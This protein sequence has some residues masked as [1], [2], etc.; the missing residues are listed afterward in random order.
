M[1]VSLELLLVRILTLIGETQ[2]IL[3]S[4]RKLVLHVIELMFRMRVRQF[5]HFPP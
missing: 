3:N 5:R 1:T 2:I 4:T